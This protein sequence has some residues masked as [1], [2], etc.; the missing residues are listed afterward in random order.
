MYTTDYL[1]GSVEDLSFGWEEDMKN[2]LTEIGSDTGNL[3]ELA[4]GQIRDISSFY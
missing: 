3:K 4:E 2:R 1:S